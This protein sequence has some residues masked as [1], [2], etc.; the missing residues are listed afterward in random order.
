MSHWQCHAVLSCHFGICLLKHNFFA[1]WNDLLFFERDFPIQYFVYHF[2]R[3]CES[4]SLYFSSIYF[5]EHFHSDMKTRHAFSKTLQIS[6]LTYWTKSIFGNLLQRTQCDHGENLINSYGEQHIMRVTVKS[7]LHSNPNHFLFVPSV[8][9]VDTAEREI[10]ISKLK[11][12]KSTSV[13]C[14]AN[15]KTSLSYTF[16][17]CVKC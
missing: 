7:F 14:L 9:S 17:M 6:E 15:W 16:T 13:V 1:C 5:Q 12:H 3:S 4:H 10:I 11:F 8:R 2:I